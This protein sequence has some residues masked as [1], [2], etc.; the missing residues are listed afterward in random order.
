MLLF[1][2]PAPLCWVTTEFKTSQG[3]L[4]TLCPPDNHQATQRATPLA[5]TGAQLSPHAHLPCMLSVDLG[6]TC[7]V[8]CPWGP[9]AV[10]ARA[11]PGEQEPLVQVLGAL[12]ET[13]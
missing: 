9:Q 10:A 7:T 4:A 8:A 12:P 5:P 6:P 2:E 1:S 11:T 13:F 3:R